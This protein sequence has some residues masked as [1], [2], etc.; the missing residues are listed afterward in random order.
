MEEKKIETTERKIIRHCIGK[1][2]T[3]EVKVPEHLQRTS[4]PENKTTNRSHQRKED[5]FHRAYPGNE[6]DKN[7]KKTN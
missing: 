1:W 5:I 3:Q 6:R 7:A 4:I 2:N